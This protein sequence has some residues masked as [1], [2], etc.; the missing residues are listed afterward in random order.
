MGYEEFHNPEWFEP[1]AGSTK[2]AK[3][4]LWT[5]YVCTVVAGEGL[6]DRGW[7]MG[8]KTVSASRVTVP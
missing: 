3:V 7:T 1:H 6:Y 5:P 4:I 8:S 2:A